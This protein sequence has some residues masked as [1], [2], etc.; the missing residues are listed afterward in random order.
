MR[1]GNLVCG[2][3]LM[4]WLGAAWAVLPDPEPAPAKPPV[5]A[6]PKPKPKP[7]PAPRREES[8]EESRGGASQ[9]SSSG[10][11]VQEPEMLRLPSGIRLGKYEV[12]Q[13]QWRS[14]MGSN[15]SRFDSCGDDCPV[16]KVSW[17][18]VQDY[19][20]RLNRQTGK[21]FRLPTEDEWYTACQAGGSHDYC[22]SDSIDAVAWYDSNSGD[23]THLVGR[24]QPNGWGLY[25]MSG[26]VEEWTSSCYDG[27]CGRRVVRGGSWCSKPSIVRA[28]FRYWHDPASRYGILGFRLA[29]D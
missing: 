17:N 2:L 3:A 29:Q 28:S 22:G 5:A 18:D 15:P 8:G 4:A 9:S 25:D 14:V 26:N 21:R 7:R 13:G 1:I 24:K 27:D 23:R 10:G 16:E 19:I 20:E 6:K 12:T 11:S